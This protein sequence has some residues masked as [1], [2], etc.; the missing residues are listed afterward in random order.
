MAKILI[1]EDD[2]F[3]ANAYRVKLSKEGY[4]V[5]IANDGSEVDG[6]LEQF[7]PDLILLDIIMPKKDGF[8]VLEELRAN[9]KYAKLPVIIASNLGQA[10]DIEKGKKLGA[11]DFI[12]KSNIGIGEILEKVKALIG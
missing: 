3:L 2:K 5:K 8:A 6:I 9:P 11:N 10:E 1:A 4:E 12:I 7:T